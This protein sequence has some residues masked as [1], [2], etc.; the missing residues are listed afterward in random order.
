MDYSDSVYAFFAVRCAVLCSKKLSGKALTLLRKHGLP[1][2]ADG[3]GVFLHGLCGALHGLF[4]QAGA[5]L[6]AA[7]LAVGAGGGMPQLLIG[8]QYA[9]IV[10]AL[11]QGDVAAILEHAGVLGAVHQHQVLRDEFG[12]DHAAG[13]VLEVEQARFF[14]M[15]LAHTLAHGDDFVPQAGGI[16]RGGEYLLAD[17]VEQLVQPWALCPGCCG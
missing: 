2:H 6:Q 10:G 15:C 9:Q 16:T 1:Q 5:V 17:A 13:A 14:G 3:A 4:I 8:W 12:I 7:Q 11:Q